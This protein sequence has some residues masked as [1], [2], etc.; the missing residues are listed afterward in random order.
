MVD[1]PNASFEG[2]RRLATRLFAVEAP[3]RESAFAWLCADPVFADRRPS[4]PVDRRVLR[5]PLEA[6]SVTRA[7]GSATRVGGIGRQGHRLCD[8]S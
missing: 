2:V 8:Q 4:P 6:E 3:V 7:I 5:Q 1:P